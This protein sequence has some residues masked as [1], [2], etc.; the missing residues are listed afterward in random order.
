VKTYGFDYAYALS[1]DEVNQILQ[2]NLAQ[3]SMVMHYTTHDPD[4]GSTITLQAELAPWSIV[5][6][7]QNNLLNMQV[8]ISQGFLELEGGAIT[9]SYDLT[10][11]SAVIQARLGWVGTGSAQDASGSG[12][13]SHLVFDP[14]GAP[15]PDTP[16]YVATIL[17]ND[18]QGNLDSVASGLLRA[19]F[20]AAIYA[21]KAA[22]KYILAS[23]DPAPAQVASWL[24]PKQWN[25]FY[26]ETADLAA[27]CFLCMLSD[28]AM[29]PPAFDS[30]ALSAS[31]NTSVLVSQQAFFANVVLPGVQAAFPSG[32]FALNCPNDQ[33]SITNKGDFDLDKV[34]AHSFVLTTSNDGNGLACQ[35]KGGGPL[36]FLFGLAKLP[37]ASYSWEV[38]TVNPLKFAN[39]AVNFADDPQP[40]LKQ[41]H[42]MPWYDWP[43]VVVLGITNVA[44]LVSMIYD[45]VENF[46]DQANK[47]G[48]GSIN[49]N[50]QKATGGN[51]GS[52]T[53]LLAWEHGDQHLSVNEARLD[54]AFQIQGT[55]AQ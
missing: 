15:D 37:N 9:G 36:K 4:S 52:L 29:P 3:V 50:V 42:D 48:M 46:S 22:L 38:D 21:N 24:N 18:P 28:A 7:G 14:S 17:I 16:G 26:C 32:A 19:Y 6:G 8:P 54:G 41:D 39:P 2:R 5:R 10:G 55:L 35:A 43:L 31:A 51:V 44:G 47:V 25:Y 45:L 34:T 33:C 20:A 13:S 12:S 11:V 49:R 40:T 23:I 1:L 27:F 53:N 30:T